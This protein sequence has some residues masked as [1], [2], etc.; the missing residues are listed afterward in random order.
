[1]RSEAE[2]VRSL[3]CWAL[4]IM[5]ADDRS[6]RIPGPRL[7]QFRLGDLMVRSDEATSVAIAREIARLGTEDEMCALVAGIRSGWGEIART[8]A[9]RTGSEDSVKIATLLLYCLRLFGTKPQRDLLEMGSRVRTWSRMAELS[10][11]RDWKSMRDD[12]E[13]YAVIFYH[14]E[15]QTIVTASEYLTRIAAIARA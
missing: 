14:K 13:G 1:M 3:L 2:I 4:G 12:F 10:P 15:R 7:S 6:T 9:R 5:A 11:G 8:R